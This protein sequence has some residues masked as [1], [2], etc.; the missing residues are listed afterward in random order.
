M[1]VKPSGHADP[2]ID[3]WR[4][5]ASLEQ[6]SARLISARRIAVFTHS[7]PDGDAVGSALALTRALAALGKHAIA[8]FLTPWSDR[9]NAVVRD[10]PVIIEHERWTDHEE[11]RDID[12]AVIVDTGSWS[13]LAD[14]RPW[15]EPRAADTIILDHHAH[16]DPGVAPA[17]YIDTA[18]A[19]ACEIIAAL[20]ARLLG[21]DAP[22]RFPL[23][24][25]EALYLGIAT[26]TGW[27]RYSNT[28]AQTLRLAADLIDAGVDHNA[29]Y[30][31]IEQSDKASRLLL[32]GRALHSIRFVHN[33][34]IAIMTI[35]LRDIAETGADMEEVG[36]FTD[37][38]QSVASVR[39]VAVLVELEP[40]LIKV[41][42]RSKAG[43]DS[44][45]V[46][47][48]AQQLGGGGHKHAAGAK[49]KRPLPEAINAVLDALIKAGA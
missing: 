24:V 25:A 32:I 1:S 11:L 37:L 7:K 36:G 14:A 10:T 46:N 12:T 2:A 39:S 26:D 23:P 15:L 34:T 9:F 6:I 5:T 27:F 38:P 35:T 31:A 13:Q 22:A 47:L 30:R 42:F 16:G 33:N 45:D 43:D 20:C 8:V 28:T 3:E 18:A 44:V 49:I 17:R 40:N 48:A 21:I 41:S 29:L 4:T 19:A